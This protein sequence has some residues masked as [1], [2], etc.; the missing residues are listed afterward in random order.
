MKKLLLVFGLLAAASLL[1]AQC[2]NCTMP[3]VAASQGVGNSA[4]VTVPLPA[5]VAANDLMIAAVHSGWCSQGTSVTAPQGWTLIAETSNTGS[6]CGSSN[7]SV[8]LST[9]YKVATA[10]EPPAY[11]FTG[12]TSQQYVGSIVVYSGVDTLNPINASSN[13]GAQD[14]CGSIVAQG[15]TTTACTRLVGV[16]FCSV[17]YSAT[18]IIPDAQLTERVDVGTTGNNPW[19]NENLEI[20][21]KLM[22]TIGA[23]GDFVSGLS[24]CSSD[25]WVT[26]AQLIA[27]ECNFTTGIRPAVTEETFS[28]TPNP[29][30]GLFQLSLVQ[31]ATGSYQITNALG[32]VVRSAQFTGQVSEIDLSGEAAGVYFI[33]VITPQGA[34]TK[35]LVLR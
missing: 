24:G 26:G 23:T 12:T 18:N 10:S 8:Q 21:D 6:G 11:I 20:S 16:F 14:S 34:T 25:G 19:G 13:F 28:V 2:S 30:E 1:R 29:T 22:T 27:L 17:N 3:F 32:Q 4:A 35:K 5:G 7:T 9:F 15:V 31:P 33:R